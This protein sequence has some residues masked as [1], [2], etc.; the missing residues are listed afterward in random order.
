MH[1][2]PNPITL[3]SGKCGCKE[4]LSLGVHLNEAL[5][6]LLDKVFPSI[7]RMVTED[8]WGKINFAGD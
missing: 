5:G 8:C 3:L 6:E 2:F 7:N 4:T 1:N